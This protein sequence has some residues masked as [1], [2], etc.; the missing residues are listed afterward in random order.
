MSFRT[1]LLAL[2]LVPV[3]VAAEPGPPPRDVRLDPHGFVIPPG[4]IGRFGPGVWS[5]VPAYHLAWV[6]DGKR[7]V[8][9]DGN[10]ITVF[11]T[12][13]GRPVET[14]TFPAPGG[15]IIGLT[16]DTRHIV[17]LGAGVAFL[18]DATTGDPVTRLRLSGPL[19]RTGRDRAPVRSISLSADGRFLACVLVDDDESGGPAWRHDLAT[20]V[21]SQVSGRKDVASICLSPD[22]RLAFGTTAGEP[23]R[24]IRWDLTAGREAWSVPF[25]AW[26]VVR[27]VAADGRRVAVVGEDVVRVFD[28]QS[29]KE[30]LNIRTSSLIGGGMRRFNAWS[31]GLDFS[32]DGRLLALPDW[33]VVNVWDVDEKKVRRRLAQPARLVAFSPDGRSLLGVDFWVQRWDV[34]TGR[35][36]YPT[37]TIIEPGNEAPVLQWSSDGRR[38][39]VW[40]HGIEGHGIDNGVPYA[41]HFSSPAAL[42]VLDVRPMTP[43]WQLGGTGLRAAAMDWHGQTVWYRTDAGNLRAV[44]LGPPARDETVPLPPDPK[45]RPET[46]PGQDFHLTRD[47][48]LLV[49]LVAKAG[50][51]TTVYDARTGRR[52]SDHNISEADDTIGMSSGW[53]PGVAPEAILAEGKRVDTLMG[54]R[55]PPILAESKDWNTRWHF[56]YPAD[57]GPLFWGESYVEERRFNGN[58]QRRDFRAHLWE[59]ATGS[60]VADLDPDRWNWQQAALSPSGRFVA[61]ATVKGMAVG[62]LADPKWTHELA[63]PHSGF[64]FSPDENL[65]ASADARDGTVLIWPLPRR[66]SGPWREADAGRLWDD[67]ASPDASR[68]WRA[69]WLLR[70]HPDHTTA[71]LAARLKPLPN[72]KGV[73]ELIARL[74]D[75]RFAT[76]EQAA[77]ELGR[78]GEAVEGELRA[79][80]RKPASAEQRERLSQLVEKLNTAAPPD[81]ETLRSLRSV[82]LLERV[83]TPAA[84]RLLGELATGAPSARVA[85][86]AKAALG[87]LP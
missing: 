9:A 13:S 77:R 47:G 75:A 62:D 28:G 35:P 56:R 12:G 70:D 79:A 33:P 86:E 61:S 27:A 26:A 20:G 5:G 40:Q 65:L 23:R 22:G 38:L 30:V 16:R 15:G 49:Q 8:T 59:S 46:Q 67:L 10:S 7:F 63:E 57:G 64:A 51:T 50:I 45:P 41:H 55:R 71:L 17:R 36:V 66:P 58:S 81:A 44:S 19:G 31:R 1:A 68:A 82:W 34:A 3:A 43:V 76:R 21:P 74:D 4:A 24:L 53:D 84:R 39:L 6:S 60:K 48:R 2:T 80:L 11:D 54:R 52:M 83:G 32:P 25:G 72:P 29:G 37:P 14:V 18:N 69:I 78:L 42:V 85:V 87:R 73:P